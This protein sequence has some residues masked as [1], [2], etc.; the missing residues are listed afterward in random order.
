MGAHHN[1]SWALGND[2]AGSAKNVHDLISGTAK[3]EHL[4]KC[5]I[6]GQWERVMA[7]QHLRPAFD[8]LGICRLQYMEIGMETEHYED[9]FEK[10]TGKRLFWDDLLGISEN[11][12]HLTRAFSVREIPGFSRKNDLPPARFMKEPTP[13]GPNQGHF[14]S[15]EEVN[16]LLDEYYAN[17]GWDENGLPRFETL[18][19]HGLAR[20]GHELYDDASMAVRLNNSPSIRALVPDLAEKVDLSLA[21]GKTVQEALLA[22]K[23]NPALVVGVFRDQKKIPLNQPLEMDCELMVMGPVAGG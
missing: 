1:R 9:F 16:L 7:L 18:S 19:R 3:T 5:Q 14:I 13:T 20:E 15:L 22:A 8:L 23:I 10:I 21:P 17:R 4:D 2:V 11:V 6:G 12:W